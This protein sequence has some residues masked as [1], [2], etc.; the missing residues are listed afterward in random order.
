M[1]NCVGDADCAEM[2]T[3]IRTLNVCV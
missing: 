1:A 3:V 2:E